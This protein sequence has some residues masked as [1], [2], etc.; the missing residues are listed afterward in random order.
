MRKVLITGTAGFIGMHVSLAFL[1]RGIR[2]IGLD[3]LNAYYEPTLK[4][5][6]LALLESSPRA[7]NFEFVRADLADSLAISSVF[8]EH[9]F[10]GVINLA[11]QAGVRYSSKNPRAYLD[12]NLTGFINI[13]EGAR[14]QRERLGR[15][16]HLVYPIS[17]SKRQLFVAAVYA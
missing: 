7:E 12:S 4:E 13:L 17:F 6:R 10:D 15:D 9:E 14:D 2:V 16:C 5:A 1:G 8:R 11:A 3:N